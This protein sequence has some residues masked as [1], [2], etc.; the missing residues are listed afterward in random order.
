MTRKIR[1][2]NIPSDVKSPLG[3]V[4][5]NDH[6]SNHPSYYIRKS[7]E[8]RPYHHISRHQNRSQSN[9]K[10]RTKSLSRTSCGSTRPRS[11]ITEE[12]VILG[13]HEMEENSSLNE[14]WFITSWWLQ[15]TPLENISQ[16]GFC[17]LNFRDEH[18]KYLKPSAWWW[19]IKLVRSRVLFTLA[20]DLLR[21][22]KHMQTETDTICAH[23]FGNMTP[24]CHPNLQEMIR[25]R[26]FSWRIHKDLEPLSPSFF[27][28]IT[29]VVPM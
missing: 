2:V 22:W 18:R 27:N 19:F 9:L 21:P 28:G 13:W 25:G 17:F 15:P 16:T 3:F 7:W 20:I 14:W 23:V 4:F 5:W 8:F 26:K 6:L 10:L 12:R 24:T 29:W 11:D 1:T